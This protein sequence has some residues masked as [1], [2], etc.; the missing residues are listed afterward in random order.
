M[1]IPNQVIQTTWMPSNTEHYK[2]LGYEY[3]GVRT[4]VKVRA[5]DLLP[6]SKY[7]VLI[8]CDYCGEIFER[9]YLL[10]LKGR[11]S[12]APK[13]ACK[14]CQKKKTDE[15]KLAKYGT[16]NM[17]DLDWVREKMKETSLEHYGCEN[18]AQSEE[19]K[20]KIKNTNLERYGVPCAMQ[21]NQVKQ[22]IAET[23]LQRYGVENVFANKEIQEKIS[24]TNK[25]RYG[26]G[27]IAHTPLI[28]EKIKQTNLK[29]YGVPYSTQAP[30]VI[31]KMRESLYK[32]GKVPSSKVEQY[33]C[34]ILEDLYGKEKCFPQ[35]AFDELN[36]DCL[37]KFKECQ[38]DV[39]Y[40]GWYWHKDK[41]VQD[42]RRNGFVLK[43]GFKILRIRSNNKLP[44]KEQI[45]EA[46]EKLRFSDKKIIYI[47]LDI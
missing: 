38:I 11:K 36:F 28:A 12:L 4:P 18:P 9:Q 13:D 43:Q 35:Y 15:S 42:Y 14:R 31:K 27:N 2:K 29:K 1:L 46:I 32:A 6:T 7:K 25:S 33:V 24:E 47:D 45:N 3:T 16:T 39:E 23:N 37:L 8:K 20:E 40:D 21:S 44:N 41:I 10:L 5:E 30:E 26:E 22:K 19:V 17:M 34:Q